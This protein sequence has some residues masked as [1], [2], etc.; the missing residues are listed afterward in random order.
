MMRTDK[1][2]DDDALAETDAQP[3]GLEHQCAGRGEHGSLEL[4]TAGTL[5]A[6]AS[7]LAQRVE[8]THATLVA[9]APRLDALADPGFLLCELLVEQ[10]LLSGLGRELRVL[11]A[12]IVGIAARECSQVCRDPAR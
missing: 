9:G 1:F 11:G 8:R 7:L 2:V 5:T 6:R 12:Q 4:Q 3:I 10:R